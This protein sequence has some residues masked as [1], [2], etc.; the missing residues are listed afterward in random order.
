[1]NHTKGILSVVNGK[2]KMCAKS[3]AEGTHQILRI[4]QVCSKTNLTTAME[5]YPTL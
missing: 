3:I 1:M 4:L 2:C 5:H